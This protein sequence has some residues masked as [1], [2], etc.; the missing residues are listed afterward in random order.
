MALRALDKQAGPG[1]A[2]LLGLRV[3]EGA[4]DEALGGV[5][6]VGRVGHGLRMSAWTRAGTCSMS[7]SA[8][9]P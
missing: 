8:S 9:I 5:D 1:A 7:D 3:I 4:A 6:R 2:R